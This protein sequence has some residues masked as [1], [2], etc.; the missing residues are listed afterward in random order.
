LKY[1]S[2]ITLGISKLALGLYKDGMQKSHVPNHR[3]TEQQGLEGISG[4]PPVQTSAKTGS[5]QQ[6]A[7]ES[8]Q[9]GFEYLQRDL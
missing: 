4:D 6:I 8:I 3:T 7:Q 5:L 1:F 2:N 9:A